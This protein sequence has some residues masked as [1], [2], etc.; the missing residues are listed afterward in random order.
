[1][2]LAHL[3][4]KRSG[5]PRGS[6]N[7]PPWVRAALWASRNLDNLEAVPPS[8]L[9]G[10]LLALGR[11]HPD[12]LVVV[13]LKAD[14]ARDRQEREKRQEL[15]AR[16]AR[17]PR[18]AKTVPGE[19]RLRKLALYGSRLFD[20]LSLELSR[21]PRLPGSVEIVGIMLST[22]NGGHTVLT[23]RSQ[24]FEEVPEGERIPEM[25]W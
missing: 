1:M 5:R 2:G 19:R 7:R 25:A 13:L 23:L 14:A 24:A 6:K 4:G 18:P 11:E 12:R 21:V 22:T 8:P 3:K 9:A 16:K 15:A 20:T 10:R 17:Q